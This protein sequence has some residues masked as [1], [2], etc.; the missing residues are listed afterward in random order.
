MSQERKKLE[1]HVSRKQRDVRTGCFLFTSG[2]SCPKG[3]GEHGVEWCCMNQ[4]LG[5]RV[6]FRDGR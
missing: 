1:I 5:G 4:R 6:M 2:L 3:H